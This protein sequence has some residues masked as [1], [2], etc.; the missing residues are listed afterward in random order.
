M[1]ELND[2]EIN[3]VSGGHHNQTQAAADA[4]AAL[5]KAFP[6]LDFHCVQISPDHISCEVVSG[7]AGQQAQSLGF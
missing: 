4:E 6:S 5:E 7:G 3:D 1:R 2:I